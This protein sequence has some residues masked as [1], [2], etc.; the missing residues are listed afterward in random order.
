MDKVLE[1][2]VKAL[3]ERKAEKIV[4]I[5]FQNTNPLAD[6]YVIC[7]G[8]NDRQINALVDNV[9]DKLEKNDFPIRSI[10][11]NSNSGWQLIDAYYVIV[12]IFNA[13]D[14]VFYGIE[15]LFI[16]KEM[17]NLDEILSDSE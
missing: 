11:G 8:T 7:H 1:T 13:S 9:I 3:D 12:H 6:Y 10:E 2:V 16:D 17:V 5:D 14:R 4:A 15:K